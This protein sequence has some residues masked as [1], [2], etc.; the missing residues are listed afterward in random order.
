VEEDAS[1]GP[2]GTPGPK[3]RQSPEIRRHRTI[4]SPWQP[5]GAYRENGGFTTRRDLAT[6]EGKRLAVQ[7]VPQHESRRIRLFAG[8]RF[9]PVT[10]DPVVVSVG[11]AVQNEYVLHGQRPGPTLLHAVNG[12]GTC[13]SEMRVFVLGRMIVPVAFRQYIY[14]KDGRRIRDSS[15]GE[16]AVDRILLGM[17]EIYAPQT[18]IRFE[19]VSAPWEARAGVDPGAAADFERPEVL[20]D[21]KRQQ[22]DG[23]AFT[24]LL[25]QKLAHDRRGSHTGGAA[26]LAAKGLVFLAYAGDDSKAALRAAHEVG[27]HLAWIRYRTTGG[28]NPDK[29]YLMYETESNGGYIDYDDT[30]AMRQ[31]IR[32]TLHSMVSDTYELD[33]HWWEAMSLDTIR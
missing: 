30:R 28:H 12:R 32:R 29:R 19:R 23:A 22:V 15:W 6:T 13:E 26:I 20:E 3:G 2:F 10:D 4:L 5:V 16:S 14:E 25:V 17:N 24:F 27:H 1:A 21:A 31:Q 8:S 9:T 33:D 18:N 7:L 11:A